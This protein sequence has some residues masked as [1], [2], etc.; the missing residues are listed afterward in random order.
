M[1]LL[2]NLIIFN[3]KAY[4][5]SAILIAYG[6]DTKTYEVKWVDKK[7][8]KH[9]TAAYGK[10]M[11]TALKS[12]LRQNQREKIESV[13]MWLWLVS[14]VMIIAAFTAVAIV[15]NAPLLSLLGAIFGITSLYQ[16]VERYFKYTK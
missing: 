10:D 8:N 14:T 3:M 6:E 15:S 7:G 1:S 13:P 2:K 11:T 16:L 9:T 5:E 4:A 12:V